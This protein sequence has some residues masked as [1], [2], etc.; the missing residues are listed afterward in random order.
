[1]RLTT[2][3]N[4][5]PTPP[6]LAIHTTF[7]LA[8]TCCLLLT[9]TLSHA[10]VFD[11]HGQPNGNW[12]TPTNWVGDVAPVS[13]SPNL[14]I[15]L[16][17]STKAAIT[18]QDI[19]DPLELQRLSIT[20][21]PEGQVSQMTI[22][23]APLAFGNLGAPPTIRTMDTGLSLTVN[24]D[25]ILN[26]DLTTSSWDG[27]TQGSARLYLNGGISGSGGLTTGPHSRGEEKFWGQLYLGGTTPNTY[28]GL[29]TI[30]EGWLY[31]NKPDSVIAVPGDLILN[32][33]ESVGTR[34]IVYGRAILLNDNQIAATSDVTLHGGDL[35]L[36][37]GDQTLANI[38][39]TGTNA[40]LGSIDVEGGTISINPS[41]ALT[42]TGE[43]TR[44]AP[45]DTVTTTSRISG[46]TLNLNAGLKT[47]RVDNGDFWWPRTQLSISSEIVNG[48]IAKA[49]AGDL[50][51]GGTFS[52]NL[53]ANEGFVG[54]RNQMTFGLHDGG[55]SNR[56]V[57]AA[58][59]ELGGTFIIDSSAITDASGSW[60]LV[61][62][63]NLTETFTT[64]FKVR[65][66]SGVQLTKIGDV[67]KADRWEFSTTSGNLTL[68]AP[69]PAAV[70][71][72]AASGA[73]LAGATRRRRGA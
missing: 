23:G 40:G 54:V 47:I 2:T 17:R 3:N 45:Y 37:A 41:H 31:L 68:A 12:S 13:G 43:I 8:T 10:A 15:S 69:E 18:N 48:G 44:T 63:G 61:D 52:G 30:N 66:A 46:G 58:E 21:P 36:E 62:V 24:N 35:V 14:E 65:L 29:T 55:I 50:L 71:M 9:G 38:R 27:I 28:A 11:G 25:L 67:F 1:M 73:A 5:R 19:R 64:S 60:N 57:G 16:V 33:P 49:G 4:R 7:R 56:I 59:A 51:L 6:G 72:L 22:N 26:D 39:F 34:N 32:R 70:S 42:V 53:F 20:G